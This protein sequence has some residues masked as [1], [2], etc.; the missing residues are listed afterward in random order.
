M[1][2]NII[3]ANDYGIYVSGNNSAKPQPVVTGNQIFAND[4]YNFGGSGFSSTSG[5]DAHAERHGQLVGHH[6][7]DGDRGSDPAT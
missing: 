4:F 6:R 2:G 5:S 3:T 7:S 1:N